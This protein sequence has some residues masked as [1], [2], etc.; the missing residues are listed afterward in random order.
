MVDFCLWWQE[1]WVFSDS[2]HAPARRMEPR[3][4]VGRRGGDHR[5][6]KARP[7]ECRTRATGAACDG[8]GRRPIFHRINANRAAAIRKRTAA[9][10][11]C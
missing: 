6:G 3:G 10:K 2:C 4:H 5:S 1:R 7:V 8:S 11:P 9:A